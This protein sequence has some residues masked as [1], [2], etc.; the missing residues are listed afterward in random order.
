MRIYICDIFAVEKKN[1]N[2]EDIKAHDSVQF[3]H[4]MIC[5]YIFPYTDLHGC[6]Y[7][8]QEE[9]Y[10]LWLFFTFIYMHYIL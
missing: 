6:I 3:L 1:N 9:I 10:I 2:K 8:F 7:R 5:G 4:H